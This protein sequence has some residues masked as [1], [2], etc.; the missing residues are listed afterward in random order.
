VLTQVFKQISTIL[1]SNPAQ[2]KQF[3]ESRGLQKILIKKEELKKLGGD[4]KTIVASI[5]EICKAYPPEMVSFF[6]PE[7]EAQLLARIDEY[8]KGGND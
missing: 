1:P 8:N 7:Y 4:H 6:S 5:D 2:K 3:A